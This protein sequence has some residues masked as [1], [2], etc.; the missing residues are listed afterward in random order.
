MPVGCCIGG[1]I[2]EGCFPSDG[3]SCARSAKG[4]NATS[5]NPNNKDARRMVVFKFVERV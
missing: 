1:L 4:I 5:S 3:K 2:L